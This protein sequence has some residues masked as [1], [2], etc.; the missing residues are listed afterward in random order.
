MGSSIYTD[1]VPQLSLLRKGEGEDTYALALNIVSI[2]YTFNDLK[3]DLICRS[4][5][6]SVEIRSILDS[7]THR[8]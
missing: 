4:Q 3:E 7:E 1:I 5:R 6:N 2:S 8:Y